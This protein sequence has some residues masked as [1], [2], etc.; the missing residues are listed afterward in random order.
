M[1]LTNRGRNTPWTV[2]IL[3]D[4][5]AAELRDLPGDLRAR[6]DHVTDLIRTSGIENVGMPHVR[7]LEGPLWE[8]RLRGETV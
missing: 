3:D 1:T 2:A 6:F 4:T 5:V 8:M 7:H